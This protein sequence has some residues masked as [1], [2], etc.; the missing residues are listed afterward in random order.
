V[1][2]ALAVFSLGHQVR[3]LVARMGI[4]R[5]A[6]LPAPAIAPSVPVH[7]TPVLRHVWALSSPV[8]GPPVA[9]LAPSRP[10]NVMAG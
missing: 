9:R 1:P 7:I 10:C 2:V 5:R 4:A 3:R 8:R 6:H